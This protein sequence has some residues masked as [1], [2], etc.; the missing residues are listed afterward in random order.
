MESPLRLLLAPTVVLALAA[1]G[2]P[3]ISTPQDI[4]DRIRQQTGHATRE[5]SADSAMPAGVSIADGMTESEAIAI[6]LWNNSGF[7]ESLADLGIAHADL[8][9]AGLPCRT[10]PGDLHRSGDHARQDLQ[11]VAQADLADLHG[12]HGTHSATVAS[13]RSQAG[14]RMPS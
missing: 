2:T 10:Q 13:P 1:C 12:S 9:Q 6:A 3:D 4:S 5:R 8:A 11:A 7:Q 14:A